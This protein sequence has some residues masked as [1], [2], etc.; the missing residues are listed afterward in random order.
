[1]GVII[2][3]KLS[4]IIASIQPFIDKIKQTDFRITEEIEQQAFKEAGD[5]TIK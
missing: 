1:M 2:K 3:A 4:K 5:K